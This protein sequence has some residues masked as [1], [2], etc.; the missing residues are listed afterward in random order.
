MLFGGYRGGGGNQ[1]RGPGGAADTVI[2][3]VMKP[4]ARGVNSAL[5]KPGLLQKLV[6]A[7]SGLVPIEKIKKALKTTLYPQYQKAC[8]VVAPMMQKFGGVAGVKII[9]FLQVTTPPFFSCSH[10][11]PYSPRTCRSFNGQR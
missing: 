3:A 11:W 1:D 9:E 10:W 2:Q 7:V 4:V 6:D 8:R 5:K